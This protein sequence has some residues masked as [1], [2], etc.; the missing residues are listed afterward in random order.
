MKICP[1]CGAENKEEA[2][3]CRSCKKIPDPD[4]GREEQ[5]VRTPNPCPNCGF[6]N[7]N[8]SSFCGKCGKPVT[9]S[10]PQE[11]AAKTADK[12]SEPDPAERPASPRWRCGNCG[13]SL[14][15][16]FDICW[17]CGTQRNVAKFGQ[18]A[19]IDV[20]RLVAENKEKWANFNLTEVNGCVV[21]LGIFEGEFHWHKHDTED[22]LFYV[23]SGKLLLDLEGKTLELLPN[24]GY[25]VPCTVPH[26]TRA[27]EKTIVLMVEKSTVRPEGDAEDQGF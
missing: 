9:P 21:R 16:T 7:D 27:G 14:E 3:Q 11:P 20:N 23:L 24:Q 22:E 15:A 2:V 18:S 13:E 17:K 10:E 5:E 8:D 1:F 6:D 25:T 19:V 12:A 26:R 4:T